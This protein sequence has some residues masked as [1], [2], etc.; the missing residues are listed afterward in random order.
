[1][2]LP[3]R[4]VRRKRSVAMSRPR[5]PQRAAL[6]DEDFRGRRHLRMALKH[7]EINPE[8]PTQI[9]YTYKAGEMG[10]VRLSELILR[11]E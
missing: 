7:R 3:H 11:G 10:A 9:G 5:P 4:R 1:M 6:G 8:T 2:I